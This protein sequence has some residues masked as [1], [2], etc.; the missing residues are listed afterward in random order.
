VFGSLYLLTG[1][2]KNVKRR[3]THST[4][5]TNWLQQKEEEEESTTT[6]LRITITSNGFRR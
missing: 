2:I 5:Q 1:E 6:T 4:T 3:V